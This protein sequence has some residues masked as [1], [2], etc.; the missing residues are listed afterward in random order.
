VRYGQPLTLVI[1][2]LDRFK[3]INDQ[4]SHAVGDE[5]LRV[6]ARI[7]QEN[8]RES[9]LVARYGGEEFVIAFSHAT[10]SQSYQL[11]ERLRVLIEA[12]P[13]H[14]IH[15]DLRVTTSM[16]LCADLT[17]GGFEQMLS[18][19]DANLYHAKSSGRNRVCSGSEVVAA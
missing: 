1:A 7:L 13:W 10:G 3:Q 8:I 17:Q 15:P 14:E 5:V 9:D 6:V 11:A 12:H 18:V 19:A 4:L 2:D 16:G